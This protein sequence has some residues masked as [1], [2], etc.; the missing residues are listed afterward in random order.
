MIVG[1]NHVSDFFPQR[2]HLE[3][4]GHDLHTGFEMN[5]IDDDEVVALWLANCSSVDS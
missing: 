5:V 4:L 3:R 1:L 2:I